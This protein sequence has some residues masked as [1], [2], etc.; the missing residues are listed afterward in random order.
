M[1]NPQG[2]IAAPRRRKTGVRG[3]PLRSITPER[4]DATTMT[5]PIS[6]T[7]VTKLSN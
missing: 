6:A 3:K 2:P 7:E 5:T 4:R 1:P